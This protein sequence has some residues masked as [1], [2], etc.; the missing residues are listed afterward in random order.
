MPPLTIRRAISFEPIP[1]KAKNPPEAP[2]SNSLLLTAAD[3]ARE[4]RCNVQ[5]IRRHAKSGFLP[6]PVKLGRQV[7]WR[8]ADIVDWIGAGCPN[9]E[10]ER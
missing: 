2:A 5:T 3:L 4:F 9:L 8:R 1:A 7:R 6:P 10:G